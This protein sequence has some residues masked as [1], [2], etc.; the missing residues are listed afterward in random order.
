[1]KFR[2]RNPI[3][4]TPLPVTVITSLIY[5][6]LF[7]AL[8]VVHLIVPPAPANPTPV[9]GINLTEAWL[10]LQ[11]LTKTYHP[12][13]SH[14][15]D[16]VR[17]WLLRRVE[18]IL[19]GNG[20]SSTAKDKKNDAVT[21]LGESPA[22]VFS[23]ISSNVSFSSPGSDGKPGTSVYFEG[24]NIIVYVRG[25]EEGE[26]G[27]W[28]LRDET[29]QKGGV[30][31]NAHYDSVS[32]GFGATDDGV[33]VVTILQLIKHFTTEGK[34]PKKGLVALLN[35]GEEDYL[36]GARV[37]SQHPMSR[38]AHTF[39]NL[40][41]AGAGGRAALFRS[42]DT[43]ITRAYKGAKH[44]LGNCGSGD[45]FRRGVI[46]SQTDYVVFNELL[47][48]R[49]LDVAFLN[50][51][52]RYH[53]DQDDT[54]HTNIDSLWH[55]LSAS[56]A[57]VETLTSDTSS[58]FDG[59]AHGKGTVPSG[60]GTTGVWFDMFG[61]SFAVLQLRTLFALSITLLVVGPIVLLLL[62]I[63]LSKVDKMYLFSSSKHHHHQERD[64]SVPLQ[65]LRGMTRFPIISLLA[66]AAVI[67]LAVLGR[68]F[69]SSFSPLCVL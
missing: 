36:N 52:A 57:T 39:L 15:N 44:P 65:G 62:G 49:G 43:Q 69:R 47:G 21:A 40:E 66:S 24:T 67:A 51:R 54:R 55:M 29:P 25:S 59:K 11:L 14:P 20:V 45:A 46:R 58:T 3:A 28:W 13:N 42:T 61:Q 60:K 19:V 7:V 10:D 48:L 1:M 4:F 23:D 2:F 17:N 30:L 27:G 63:I 41:G 8:L 56:L 37:F 68:C 33:G 53:T 12:Y 18:A 34:Q 6:T 26:E 16:N 50:P 5:V 64:D 22:V 32:T 35:N 31:V 38:F 9:S